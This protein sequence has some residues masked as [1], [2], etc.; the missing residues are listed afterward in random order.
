MKP[1]SIFLSDFILLLISIPPSLGTMVIYSIL[2]FVYPENYSAL[3]F[4][5]KPDY[6]Y[7]MSTIRK[8]ITEWTESELDFPLDNQSTSI[9]L[10]LCDVRVFAIHSLSSYQFSIIVLLISSQIIRVLLWCWIRRVERNLSDRWMKVL[11]FSQYLLFKSG[12]T[13]LSGTE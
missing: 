6:Y 2:F 4:F 9:N 1:W 7:W 8:Q 11:D 13:Q 12:I 3:Q 5:E 10:L